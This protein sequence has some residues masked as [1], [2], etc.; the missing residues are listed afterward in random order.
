MRR[1]NEQSGWVPVLGILL[2]C[3]FAVIAGGLGWSVYNALDGDKAAPTGTPSRQTET[4]RVQDASGSD[5]TS[6]IEK[7]QPLAIIPGD[8]KGK[9]LPLATSSSYALELWLRL[10]DGDDWGAA[11]AAG[12]WYY[13][14]V[15]VLARADGDK[16]L[17]NLYFNGQVIASG[18]ADLHGSFHHLVVNYGANRAELFVDGRLIATAPAK[19]ATVV[20]SKVPLLTLGRSSGDNVPAYPW[21][22]AIKQAALYKE[23]LTPERVRAHYASG[24]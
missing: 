7:D 17:I 8:A 2:L 13:G 16:H 20:A 24:R 6:E 4:T 21:P 15:A 5:Y 14:P 18:G 10:D 11:A 3:L 23:P 9:T 1:L 12:S 22:G 19:P